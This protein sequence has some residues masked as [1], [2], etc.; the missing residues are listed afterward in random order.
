MLTVAALYGLLAPGEDFDFLAASCALSTRLDKWSLCF[1]DD[2]RPR[3]L[4]IDFGLRHELHLLMRV[5]INESDYMSSRVDFQC[6]L[7][8]VD[9]K[10][11]QLARHISTTSHRKV[12]LWFDSA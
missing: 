8:L 6:Q 11:N 9:V 5:I 10:P 2:A 3:F 1:V 12:K 7:C 4:I